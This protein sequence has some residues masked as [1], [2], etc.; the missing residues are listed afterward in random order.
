MELDESGSAPPT[1]YL[2]DNK[3][4]SSASDS[5][6][7]L[8]SVATYSRE[9]LGLDISIMNS[10]ANTSSHQKSLDFSGYHIAGWSLYEVLVSTSNIAA[11]SEREVVGSNDTPSYLGFRIYEHD[12]IAHDYYNQLA[13]GFYNMNHNGKLQNIS[14]LYASPS[15]DPSNQNY[16]YFD[17]RSDYQDGSTN[18]VSSVQLDNVGLTSTWANVTESVML[19]ADTQYYAVMNGSTLVAYEGFYPNIRWYYQDTAG[20]FLTRRHNTDGNTWGSDRPFE[21]LL[22]YTYTPWNTTSNSA[23]DFQDPQ[24]IA[25]QGN[26]SSLGGSEWLFSS[27]TNVSEVQFS[28]NQSISIDYNLTLRYKKDITSTS[29]WYAGT[30]GTDI[31]WN[32]TSIIDFPELSGSQDKNLTLA[33][34]TDWT[35]NHLFNETSPT[36]YYDHFIQEGSGVECYSLAD[37]TWILECTSPNYLQSLSKYDSSNNNIITDKVSVSVTMDIN[38]TIESPAA[39]PATNGDAS[40]RV[41]YQSTVEYAENIS[42]TAGTSHHQWDISTD[43]SSNGLHSIDLYWMNGTEAGYLTSDV[44]VYYQTNLDADDYFIDAFTEN[45]F[46]IGVDFNQIFPATG[47]DSSEADVTYSVGAVVNQSLTDQSNGRWDATVSTASIAPGTHNLYVYAEGYAIE[48]KSLI[49]EI[50]LI[51]EL[52]NKIKTITSI[53]MKEFNK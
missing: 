7:N 41:F 45:T 43:S 35:A 51:H 52:L 33:L 36:E 32:I 10:F 53:V 1:P 27:A 20:S 3:L 5:G 17:I 23:L 40:L 9:M 6:N 15:Y 18:M 42:V 39:I 4:V 48:N 31:I 30:S 14:L 24:A 2:F 29:S 19:D 22:N 21:A 25:L 46:Y 50:T 12:D 34:P 16:A 49:I 47:I 38:A 26:S 8:D 11:I 13:Q 28:S 44:L 37:E